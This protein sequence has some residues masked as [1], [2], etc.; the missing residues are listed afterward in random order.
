MYSRQI[1]TVITNPS[2]SQHSGAPS[3]DSPQAEFMCYLHSGFNL[4]KPWLA[5]SKFLGLHHHGLPDPANVQS[6]CWH[7]KGSWMLPA[8]CTCPAR[9][10]QAPACLWEMPGSP[11]GGL[12]DCKMLAGADCHYQSILPLVFHSAL[13][14]E[15]EDDYPFPVGFVRNQ[16]LN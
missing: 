2:S 6:A 12:S 1:P 7:A 3:W 4:A 8:H 5:V 9:H 16:V 13:L 11:P 10:T 15:R 14:W